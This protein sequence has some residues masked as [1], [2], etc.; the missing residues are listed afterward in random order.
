MKILVLGHLCLDVI[1]PVNG[2][3]IESLG[4]IYYAVGTLASLLDARD[5][6]VPVFGVNREEYDALL[7]KFARF[8]NVD[9]A[10]IFPFDE[11]TNRVHL[12]YKK[13]G[14]RIECSKDISRPIPFERIRKHLGADAVLVN[15]VSGFDLTLE[16][17]DALRMAIRGERIPIHFDFHSLTLG[18][19]ET[20][21]RYR[22]PVEEWRRWAFM[23][24][25]VQLN[26]EEIAGLP[27]EPMS[28]QQTAGH[29]LT[30][31]TKAILVTRGERG[32]SLYRNDQKHVLRTDFPGVP[33]QAEPETTGCGD[34]FG[35][36]FLFQY[37]RS[38]DLVAATEFAN[39]VSAAK[40]RMRGVDELAGLRP[41][42]QSA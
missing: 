14:S 33:V 27:L 1:H 23:V 4:G 30:L 10:G 35:A 15:M 34:V 31:G 22:R 11:P 32:V 41:E 6:V 24:D 13:R 39:R 40:V 8:P 25:S 28:E 26:E 29:L 2:P 42:A 36:A 37:V 12:Y 18:V 7:E 3:E 21:S 9:P 17:M 19:T 38:A 5:R 16:T 20:H